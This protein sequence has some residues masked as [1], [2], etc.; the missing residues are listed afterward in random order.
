MARES[1]KWR[2]KVAKKARS[3]FWLSLLFSADYF[4]AVPTKPSPTNCLWPRISKG[5]PFYDPMILGLVTQSL[6]DF[7]ITI[8]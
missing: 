1:R 3:F 8:C 7:S 2:K 6:I 5:T 4:L